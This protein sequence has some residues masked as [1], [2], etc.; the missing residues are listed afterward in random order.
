M[1]DVLT[2]VRTYIVEELSE[3]DLDPAQLVDLT[4]LF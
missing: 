2:D 1:T 4:N 3:G